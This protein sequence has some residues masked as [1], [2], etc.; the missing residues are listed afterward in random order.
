VPT[1]LRLLRVTIIAFVGLLLAVLTFSVSLWITEHPA[2][3]A[4]SL[5]IDA[6]I[7]YLRTNDR[8]TLM[9]W[10]DRM[11]TLEKPVPMF[12]D[13]TRY[14]FALL[15]TLPEP[16]WVLSIYRGK[17]QGEE[18][19]SSSETARLL[20][21]SSNRE[22]GPLSQSPLLRRFATDES[23]SIA[24]ID[25][26]K[27][28]RTGTQKHAVLES[29]LLGAPH[30][31]LIN[32]TQDHG[33]IVLEGVRL[34]RSLQRGTVTIA[35]IKGGIHLSVYNL[36]TV[37]TTWLTALT[38]LDPHLSE[39]MHGIIAGISDQW[40]ID[41]SVEPIIERIASLPLSMSLKRDPKTTRWHITLRGTIPM[42]SDRTA[43]L[44]ALKERGGKGS[45]R[46]T[47]LDTKTTLRDVIDE[48]V[49]EDSKAENTWS[50]WALKGSPELWIALK[51]SSF[52]LSTDE[53]ALPS[54][55]KP[56]VAPETKAS[57]LSGVMSTSVLGSTITTLL[58]FMDDDI[59]ALKR[60]GLLTET[61]LMFTVE[62][63]ND[64]VVI[65]WEK[66]SEPSTPATMNSDTA[67][68]S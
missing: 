39:G 36:S 50:I 67:K 14:E 3:L 64:V 30:I 42:S 35:P 51:G 8:A 18:V 41:A 23:A 10:V 27:M 11:P 46:T 66:V 1:P 44:R 59:Q 62:P 45:T 54:P 20:L 65:R 55:D 17:I 22:H 28:S 38:H 32:P 21:H 47:I 16:A 58:P 4:S 63:M 31:L 57:F 48:T 9:R 15:D 37:I 49:V 33:S 43:L 29:L 2:L 61:P 25:T 24:W 5:P 12:T 60:A 19:L 53:S 68:K 26:V 52:V 34:P 40:N 13:G 56:T 6:T 7:F